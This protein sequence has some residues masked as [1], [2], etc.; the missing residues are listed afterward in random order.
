MKRIHDGQAT[1]DKLGHFVF[2]VHN[3]LYDHATDQLVDGIITYTYTRVQ[4]FGAI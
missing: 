3:T 4:P 2:T 1:F